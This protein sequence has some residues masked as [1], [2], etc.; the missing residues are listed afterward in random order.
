MGI[1]VYR[2]ALAKIPLLTPEPGMD[3]EAISISAPP[4]P[5]TP[6][7]LDFQRWFS[8][9]TWQLPDERWEEHWNVGGRQYGLTS[10]RYHAA[11][12]GYA[13]A[14]IGMRTPAYPGLTRKIIRNTIER[15]LDN[16]AW[17]YSAHYWK[18]SADDPSARENIMYTGHLLH[19]LALYEAWTGD[20]HYRREGFNFVRNAPV[21]HNTLSLA[22]GIARQ[23]RANPSGGVACEP[24]LIFFP[25]N[26]HPQAA[27]LL[28]EKMGLGDWK[29]ERRKWERWAL[30]SYRA[31]LGD[32]LFRLFYHQPTRAF[33]PVGLPGGDGWSLLWY[34]PW[35]EREESARELW[36][37]GRAKFGPAALLPLAAREDQEKQ[38]AQDPIC[39]TLSAR[40]PMPVSLSFLAAAARACGDP[41][42][43]KAYEEWL[44]ER[45]LK[46]GEGLAYLAVDREWQIAVTANRALALAQK[47]G[48][49]LRRLIQ[50]PP[51]RESFQ[52]P[53]I[54][55][56][57]PASTA[58]RQAYHD[59]EQLVVQLDGSD[60]NVV[61]ELLNTADVLSVEPLSP[62]AWSYE[63]GSL[64][65]KSPGSA[66]LRIETTAASTKPL[67]N[68]AEA[69]GR[70]H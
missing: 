66:P 53:L 14:T 33:C 24:G 22:E 45:H 3:E 68:D 16:R 20:D 54:E 63:Q 65:L 32:G 13:A 50:A 67:Q 30:A 21:H 62:D 55:A 17:E 10:I 35:A 6:L 70:S 56:V 31:R 36:Q 34:A 41:A 4:P 48:S 38:E 59:G 8:S 28:L 42:S 18:E 40:V 23:I 69:V 12:V 61:I 51:T 7:E 64:H 44:D 43:A 47:E 58:V 49:N 46:R 26:D 1:F 15:L 5:L 2:V 25:C 60:S 57:H 37:Q 39:A 11:F 9:I 52:R 19:L 29:E 27:L